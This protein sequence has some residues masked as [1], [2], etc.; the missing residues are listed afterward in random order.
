[1]ATQRIWL[2]KNLES[3]AAKA[4][5]LSKLWICRQWIYSATSLH[6]NLERAD[7]RLGGKWQEGGHQLQK[8]TRFSYCLGASLIRSRRIASCRTLRSVGRTGGGRVDTLHILS[9]RCAPS[10]YFAYFAY[11]EEY[12]VCFSLTFRERCE[13]RGELP[14][15]VRHD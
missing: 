5:C 14:R 15:Y 13:E 2:R 1:M 11:L 4:P 3:L 9:E 10:P 7:R 8:P 6:V 12:K